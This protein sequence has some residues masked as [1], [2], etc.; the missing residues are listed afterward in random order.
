M[1]FFSF[2]DL[3]IFLKQN[4]EFC[5]RMVHEKKCAQKAPKVSNTIEEQTIVVY[6]A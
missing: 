6:V 2:E 5:F 3:L 4:L 1:I